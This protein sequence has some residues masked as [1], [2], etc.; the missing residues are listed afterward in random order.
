[1]SASNVLLQLQKDQQKNAYLLF[2][3]GHKLAL[4]KCH[5]YWVSFVR[6][7]VCHG[8]KLIHELPREI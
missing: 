7:G 1:M 6:E 3:T 2:A 8:H 4:D 5:Y